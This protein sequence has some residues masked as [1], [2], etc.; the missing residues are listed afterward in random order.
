MRLSYDKIPIV[1]LGIILGVVILAVPFKLAA[2]TVLGSL[3]CV[4]ILFR[5]DIGFLL[6][7]SLIPFEM[8]GALTALGPSAGFTSISIIKILALLTS[9]SW[10][11]QKLKTRAKLLTAPQLIVIIGLIFL[12]IFSFFFLETHFEKKAKLYLLRYVIYFGIF[13]MTLNI[14]KSKETVRRLVITLI[15]VGVAASFFSFV[16]R[17]VPAFHGEAKTLHD[18]IYGLYGA[19]VDYSEF[20][21]LGKIMRTSSGMVG[22]DMFALFL[23]LTIPLSL[24]RLELSTPGL[25]KLGW[26]AIIGIQI[27]AL[28]LTYS[29][30][31]AY[32][33]L[34]ILLLMVIRQII[35]PSW[36]KIIIAVATLSMIAIVTITTSSGLDRMFSFKHIRESNSISARYELIRAGL[37]MF[38]DHNWLIGVGLSNF[39]YNL[40][41]YSETIPFYYE[42]NNEYLRVITEMGILGLFLSLILFWLTFK[43]FRIAQKNYQKKGDISMCNL[44]KTLEICFVGFLF[45]GLT[46][47]T[48]GRKEWPL[49]M[50]LAI[51]LKRLSIRSGAINSKTTEHD[52]AVLLTV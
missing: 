34:I 8:L 14:V 45:F 12:A 31:G 13:F 22:H 32:M 47:T 5:P 21:S 23:A 17:W 16:Q 15:V 41:E 10:L 33:L 44:A 38:K 49:V 26:S 42:P 7:V 27:L 4:I 37:N 11:I 48:I 30:G 24:Y 28:A 40:P 18:D 39:D 43:D 20:Y 3:V 2:A 6:T 19:I 51:V 35:K 46:Q 1:L 36:E 25:L 29:R 50:A 52:E 9:L